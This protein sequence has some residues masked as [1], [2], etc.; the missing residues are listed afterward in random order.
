MTPREKAESLVN[1]FNKYS[2]S[3]EKY[4]AR[5]GEVNAK[6]ISIILADQMVYELSDLPR[7]PYNERITD[8][9]KKVKTELEKINNHLS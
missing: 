9:W 7:I 6:K 5:S 1:R 4:I 3:D 8:Y 2:K